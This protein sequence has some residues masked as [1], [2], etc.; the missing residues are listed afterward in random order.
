ME[1]RQVPGFPL[2][3]VSDAGLVQG[4]RKLLK[5]SPDKD[6]YLYV[7]LRRAGSVIGSRRAVHHLVLIAFV[8][9]RGGHKIVARHKDSN[10]AHNA[11]GNLSWSTQKANLADRVARGTVPRGESQGAAKLTDADVHTIRANYVRY[12]KTSGG[13]ALAARFGVHHTTIHDIVA[14]KRTW[15]HI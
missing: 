10:P 6:G 5:L 3:T 8:G 9:P 7:N 11:L 15:R 12:S 1:W 14:R 13:K 2:Y 4:P